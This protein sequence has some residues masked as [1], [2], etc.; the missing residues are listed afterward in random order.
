MPDLLLDTDTV[1]L[2][3]RGDSKVTQNAIE[4]LKKDKKLSFSE[5]TWYEIIR[6]FRAIK[7]DRQMEIFEE[8]CRECIILPLD[9][10]AL[11]TAVDIYTE[12][13]QKGELIGEVDILIASVAKSR[14]MGIVTRNV[15]H[16]SRISNLVVQDWSG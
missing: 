6:G 1:S 7:A 14:N 5:L 12:L 8:F 16:F 11:Q 10:K 15:K 4:Y 2:L 9:R 13:R 3:Q